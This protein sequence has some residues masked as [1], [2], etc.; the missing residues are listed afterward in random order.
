MKNAIKYFFRAL[1]VSII[2]LFLFAVIFHQFVS[3]GIDQGVGQL[4]I[5]FNARPIEDVMKDESVGDS[6]KTKLRLVE[7]VKKFAVDSLGLKESKNYTTLYD[8]HGKP[9][10]WVL[11]AAEKYRMKSFEWWFPVVGTVGYKGFFK[12]NNAQKEEQ[13]LIERGYDTDLGAT[14]AW[15]TLGWFRD[16]ILSNVLNRSEGQ[17]AE[18]FIH[19]MTH[20]TLY[21]K[22]SVDFNENLASFI[23]EEGAIQFLKFK[24]GDSST[25]V[26]DYLNRKEDYDLFSKQMLI[27]Q[28]KLETLYKLFPDAMPEKDKASLKK[29]M[30][31]EIISSLDTVSFHNKQRY[32]N[33]FAG[34]R[35]PN[36]AFFL[37]YQRYDSKKSDM[38]KEM[39]EKFAGDFKKYLNYLIN[40]FR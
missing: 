13:K 31:L 30:I 15:S 4:G 39:E 12:L 27:G 19:E 7:E 6:I 34:D 38:K 17:I 32:K 33:Y 36:N 8:Q 9:V 23:G 20:A 22:S 1:E 18:L 40:K 28:K 26:A 3:Y 5:V 21:V 2:L 24:F 14:S 16:P 10:L 25:V 11:T 29:L 37:S 35:L